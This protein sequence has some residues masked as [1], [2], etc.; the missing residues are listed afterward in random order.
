MISLPVWAGIFYKMK[1]PTIIR[2]KFSLESPTLHIPLGFFEVEA[3]CLKEAHA[4][5]I[6]A[7]ESFKPAR[8]DILGTDFVR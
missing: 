3:G 2:I 5:F 4:D 6:Q 1:K 8:L 7:F